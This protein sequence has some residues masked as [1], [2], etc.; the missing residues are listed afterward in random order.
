MSASLVGSEMCIRDRSV[1]NLQ[2]HEQRPPPL[3][4]PRVSTFKMLGAMIS[5]DG[6]DSAMVGLRLE[7]ASRAFWADASVL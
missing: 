4:V 1:G 5:E 7:N 6:R 2:A 3:L